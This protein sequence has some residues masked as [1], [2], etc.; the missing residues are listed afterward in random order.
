MNALFYSC[1]YMQTVRLN[2]STLRALAQLDLAELFHE[3]YRNNYWGSATKHVFYS[4][5]GSH[6]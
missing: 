1:P 5:S 6:D 2:K 3:I 4:G